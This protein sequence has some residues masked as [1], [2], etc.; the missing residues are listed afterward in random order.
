MKLSGIFDPAKDLV[1]FLVENR[2]KCFPF[3]IF[4]QHPGVKVRWRERAKIGMARIFSSKSVS[5]KGNSVIFRP[6][7]CSDVRPV[8][9]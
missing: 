6:D 9:D 2:C 1:F 3:K 5:L 8:I 7:K 4:C